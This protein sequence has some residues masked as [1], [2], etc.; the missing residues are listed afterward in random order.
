MNTS[1]VIR[2]ATETDIT[3]I[4]HIAHTTWPDTYGAIISQ[5]QMD[6]MLEWMYSE[7]SLREQM[8]QGHQFYMAELNNSAFGFASVSAEGDAVYKLNKIYVTPLTQKTGAG[9]ALLQEVIGYARQNGGRQLLLQ[10]NRHNNA[11]GFYEKHGFTI[12]KEADFDIGNGYF[13]ND[14]VMGLD[15]A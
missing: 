7:A 6:H 3:A 14:Y 15:L 8:Q 10:V 12:L 4:R 11:K 1:L 9:K 5:A 13:M 2:K